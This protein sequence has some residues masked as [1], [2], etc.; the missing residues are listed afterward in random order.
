MEIEKIIAKI[1]TAPKIT[2]AAVAAAGIM[3]FIYLFDK[4][5][6]IIPDQYIGAMLIFGLLATFIMTL[7][8]LV[9][10]EMYQQRKKFEHEQT[11]KKLDESAKKKSKK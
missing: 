4:K 5:V 2:I 10:L 8:I 9:Y 7:G 1:F 11:M 6:G 3:G